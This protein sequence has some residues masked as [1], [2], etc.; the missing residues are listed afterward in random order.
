MTK[1]NF[2]SFLIAAIVGV[3]MLAMPSTASAQPAPGKIV[4]IVVDADGSPVAEAHV[5]LTHGDRVVA[6]A[7]TDAD[8]KYVFER[9]RPGRYLLQAGKREV[10]RG[11]ERAAVRPG[12]TVRVRIML[13]K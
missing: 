1:R 5:V 8:G 12:E 2:L 3:F 13:K 10:G 6:R 9:V 4:G 11:R 7:M